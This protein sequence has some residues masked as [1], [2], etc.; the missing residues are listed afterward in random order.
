MAQ[1][2]IHIQS[3]SA[4]I[5][6]YNS[7]ESFTNPKQAQQYLSEW[8]DKLNYQDEKPSEV[9]DGQYFDCRD[10]IVEVEIN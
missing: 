1:I 5:T 6:R 7:S 4:H 3:Q 2:K 9:Q 10:Y 8:L